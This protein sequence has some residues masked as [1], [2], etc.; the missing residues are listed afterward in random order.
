MVKVVTGKILVNKDG[1][2]RTRFLALR[3]EIF[4]VEGGQAG[5]P[6]SG[7][8]LSRTLSNTSLLALRLARTMPRE[9]S[10][11]RH[12]ATRRQDG[13]GVPM[14]GERERRREREEV[15]RVDQTMI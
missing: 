10:E 6:R 2:G 9:E 3:K 5:V 8:G 13:S 15:R 11:G 1:T 14:A 7:T 12:R 4:N